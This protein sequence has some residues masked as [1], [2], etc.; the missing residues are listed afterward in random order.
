M[1]AVPSAAPV[2][3]D[4]API[5]PAAPDRRWCDTVGVFDLETTGGNP[6]ECGITE[7]GAVRVR[8]GVVLGELQTFVDPGCAIPPFIQ[9]LT[10]ITD[11]MVR[12]APRIDAALP[13]FLEFARGAV[14]VAHNARFDIG[15]L[16]AACAAH[17]LRWPG[18]QVID[19]VHLEEDH[20]RVTI[21]I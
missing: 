21:R 13:A 11:A 18:P 16:K 4:A 20:A 19:T 7:I 10:G 9:T 15:F 1:R 17:G 12:D 8:G 3:A 2:S 6:A 5:A 14:L